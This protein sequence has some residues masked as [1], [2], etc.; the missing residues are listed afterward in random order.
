MDLGLTGKTALVTGGSRGLG[1]QAA[2][3]LA[4]EGCN[5]AICARGQEALDNAVAEIAALGVRAIGI[6]ADVTTQEGAERIHQETTAALGPVDV[7]VNNVGGSTGRDFDSA[8]DAAWNATLQ[9]SLFSGIR[10]V[11]LC[12]PSMKS[13]RWGRIISISSIYGR[14]YGGGLT[15][16]T[17]KASLIAFSKHLAIE[18]AADGIT[19]NTI[20]P[21]SIAFPGGGW[22]R[23]QRTNTKEVVDEFVRHNLPMGRFGWPEPIGATVAFLSSIQAD[24]ITGACINVDG[25]QSRSLI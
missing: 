10:L 9:L 12:L 5:V 2:I 24:L 3:A 20:A 18:V 19:V 8:D 4:K 14:E 25:G 21:G 11:R 16:M 17:A 15:Y 23:F 1:R 6:A 22:D 13:R 7:L